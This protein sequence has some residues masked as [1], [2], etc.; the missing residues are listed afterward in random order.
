ML[1]EHFRSILAGFL[2]VVVS[3]LN[4]FIVIYCLKFEWKVF[5]L[6]LLGTFGT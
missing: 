3:L 1:N 2:R 5:V 4:P 6:E